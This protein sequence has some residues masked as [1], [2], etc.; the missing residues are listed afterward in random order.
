MITRQSTLLVGLLSISLVVGGCKKKS[1]LY[2]E[3]SNN[4]SQPDKDVSLR[5]AD[6]A[7][8]LAD[9]GLTFQDFLNM[10]NQVKENIGKGYDERIYLEDLADQTNED[11]RSS[12]SSFYLKLKESITASKSSLRSNTG[13]NNGDFLIT[14]LKG[15]SFYWPN[16]DDWN[17]KEF[18]V[19][20]YVDEFVPN[21]ATTLEAYKVDEDGKIVGTIII[22]EEYTENNPVLIVE[23]K[24]KPKYNV[25]A[26]NTSNIPDDF[27]DFLNGSGVSKGNHDHGGSVGPGSPKDEEK[28]IALKLGK[29]Q[30]TKQWDNWFRGGSEFVF[31]AT[32]VYPEI[33]TDGSVAYATHTSVNGLTFTRKEIKRKVEKR[34]NAYILSDHKHGLDLVH[35]KIVEDDQG[36]FNKDTILKLNFGYK[37]TTVGVEIPGFVSPFQEVFELTYSWDFFISSLNYDSE[38]KDFIWQNAD[39]LHWTFP[40]VKGKIEID[41]E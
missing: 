34:Y 19:V 24:H 16:C 28:I 32:Y 3:P 13:F 21:D 25:L 41:A 8:G 22:D 5:A 40:V 11:L 29:V 39:G 9:G 27:S 38:T 7:Q 31:V 2:E 37:G 14:Q 1:N 23:K 30:A 6:V 12:G 4:S 35:W 15:M 26:P 36:W 10:S 17:Y 33:K 18:P 20:A